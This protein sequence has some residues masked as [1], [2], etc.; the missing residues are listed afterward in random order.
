VPRGPYAQ[1][2]PG[3][4]TIR[5]FE[6]LAC[7]IPLLSAPWSDC[8]Q[9]FPADAFVSVARGDDMQAALQRILR[10]GAFAN[11]LAAR[12]LQAINERHTC[13]HR[14]RELLGIVNAVKR[15]DDRVHDTSSQRMAS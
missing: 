4:P 1:T 15:N 14:A 12:G 6:A 13:A 2:L 3:I 10:D 5:I 9:L 7:G 8:E 11:E